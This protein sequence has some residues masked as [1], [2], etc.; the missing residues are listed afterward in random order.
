MATTLDRMGLRVVLAIAWPIMVSMVS[1]S[2]LVT[3]DTIFVAHQGTTSL[4]AVG[5]AGAASF[6]PIAFGFG[7]MAAVGILTSQRTGAG[8]DTDTLGAQ[9]LGLGLATGLALWVF[10]P[11]GP[12]LF[13][14]LGASPEATPLASAFFALRMFAAPFELGLA[15]LSGWFRGRG[16]TRTP[17]V[18][19]LL[20]NGLNIA[21]AALFVLGMGWGVPGAAAATAIA[22]AIGLLFLWW[23]LGG[24]PARPTWSLVRQVVATG[25]P[26]GVH[27]ALDVLAFVIFGAIL[28]RLGEAELASHLIVLRIMSMSFLPGHAISEATSVLVGQALG[29]RRPRQARQAMV[30]GLQLAV[31]L[32]TV[33]GAVFVLLPAQL[34]AVFAAAPDV[35]RIACQLLWVGAT[36]QVF[37]AVAMVVMGALRGAGDTRFLFQAGILPSWLV[38]LPVGAAAALWLGWGAVGAW[39]GL[40]AEMMVVAAVVLYR[41]R[42]TG[43]LRRGG[44]HAAMA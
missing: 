25:G 34:V 11:I 32:M 44:R 10:A 38:K 13:P 21:L 41:V 8:R 20:T 23:R 39:M 26:M 36:F 24:L 15:A 14:L 18:A 31:G 7:L 6:I 37:D 4:A 16:D 30:A 1:R 22:L 35:T 5:L 17:M 19:T 43:W 33:G 27:D 12:V 9:A 29:A 28:A 2:L 40:T 3:V 42:G